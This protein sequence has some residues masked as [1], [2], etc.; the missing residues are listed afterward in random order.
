MWD[1]IELQSSK[2]GDSLLFY[3]HVGF[4]I[5]WSILLTFLPSTNRICVQQSMSRRFDGLDMAI[6]IC[7]KPSLSL[8]DLL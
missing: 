1:I 5:F 6:L 3:Y 2:V 4:R 7:E 8:S